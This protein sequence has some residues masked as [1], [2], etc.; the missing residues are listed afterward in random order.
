MT[1]MLDLMGFAALG[2]QVMVTEM[3]KSSW[4]GARERI[5]KAFRRAGDEAETRQ[6]SMLDEDREKIIQANDSTRP[7][8]NKELQ[9]RWTVLL[10]AFL[11]QYPEARDDLQS[12]ID[13]ADAEPDTEA[14]KASLSALNNVNSQV[15]QSLGSI[16]TGGGSITYRSPGQAE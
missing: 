6:I 16:N 4:T 15:I 3:L 13:A 9:A 12:M 2:A 7:E 1:E 11:Q 8:V 10:A 14:A 5:A